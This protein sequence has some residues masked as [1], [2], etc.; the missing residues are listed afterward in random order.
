M[1]MRNTNTPQSLWRQKNSQKGV[2]KEKPS[3]KEPYKVERKKKWTK[4][5]KKVS[6]GLTPHRKVSE[7]IQI[8][9]K[10]KAGE[11]PASRKRLS[12]PKTIKCT[13]QMGYPAE[14]GTVQSSNS[15][16]CNMR[17]QHPPCPGI[18]GH[19]NRRNTGVIGSCHHLSTRKHHSRTGTYHQRTVQTCKPRT[20]N[21]RCDAPA[22]RGIVGDSQGWCNTGLMGSC[23]HLSTVRTYLSGYLLGTVQICNSRA[24]NIT[25]H[26]PASGGRSYRDC[27]SGLIGSQHHFPFQRGPLRT[28]KILIGTR[29]YLLCTVQICNQRTGNKSCHSPACR[30]IVG[31]SQGWCKTGL[32]GSCHHLSTASTYPLGTVQIYKPRTSNK[33]CHS[34]AWRDNFGERDPYNT[35]LTSKCRRRNLHRILLCN[36]YGDF[37][38]QATRLTRRTH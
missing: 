5:K 23:H 4:Q 36:R 16:A 8:T 37:A 33:N 22:W 11:M 20:G 31:D 35:G 30:G 17:R 14:L 1:N 26:P 3:Q 34:P 15:G 10:R 12:K 28:C 27:K 25:G 7:K 38:H 29:T 9:K 19:R 6:N 13:C 32:L 18:V 2:L 24:C 21:K